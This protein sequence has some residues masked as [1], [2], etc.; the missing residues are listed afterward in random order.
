MCSMAL[1]PILTRVGFADKLR[2]STLKGSG[3]DKDKFLTTLE[4]IVVHGKKVGRT[5]GIPTA[6]IPFVPGQTGQQDGVYVADLVLLDQKNRV[7]NG[8][9]NQGYHPTVP[10]GIPAVEIYLFDFN[11]DI[12]DQRVLVRYLHFLRPEV[13]FQTK[14][15]MRLVMQDDIKR[16]RAYFEDRPKTD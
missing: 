16:A 11:E 5:L 12:Y 14:E 4:G 3:M 13:T 1:K 6:N 10:G 2:P 15:E 9:L 8:V 7:V